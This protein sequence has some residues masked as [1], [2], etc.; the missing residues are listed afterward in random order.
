MNNTLVL[1]FILKRSKTNHENGKAPIYLRVTINGVRFEMSTKI[2]V[3]TTQWDEASQ[4]IKGRKEEARQTNEYLNNIQT[5]VQR[6][7]YRYQETEEYITADKFKRFLK[8]KDKTHKQLLEVFDEVIKTV[9]AELDINYSIDTVKR[10]KI[11]VERLRAY[12]NEI[13]HLDDIPL[14]DLDY[15]FAREYD[16]F[17][18]KTYGCSHNTAMKYIKHLKK[19]IHRAMLYEYID[20]DPFSAYKT[21]YKDVDRG[22][23]T[24]EEL[25]TIEEKS[26]RV[27][28]LEETK[29]IF[30]FVCYTGLSYSDL[31]KLSTE[32]IVKGTDGELWI[33]KNREK[34]GVQS[35]IPI[36]PQAL[37]ILKKYQGHPV[38]AADNK[39]LPIRS[40]Q[41]L[42]AYLSE[43]AELCEINKHITMHL[44]RHT[45]ATTVTLSNDVPIETVQKML[46]HKNL[47]TT[48]IY[49]RVVDSKIANDMGRL[50]KKVARKK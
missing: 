12:I 42:N 47:S 28:R 40:N 44:G 18:R 45:F 15:N 48:Q 50:R 6:K 21:A 9:E 1:N 8:G 5:E 49:S 33:I 37:E 41:K 30:L 26:F 14:T 17:L 25:R 46:G 31:S 43:I 3:T 7:F 23:L 27:T 36:L 38:C 22:F 35:R 39:I 2:F 20:R 24:T 13:H 29:D 4:R 34:T 16:L 10:Y 19:V 32:H 11:S